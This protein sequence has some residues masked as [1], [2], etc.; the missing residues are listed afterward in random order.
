MFQVVQALTVYYKSSDAI[1]N[2]ETEARTKSVTHWNWFAAQK[3]QILILPE[4]IR[5]LL[6]GIK[7]FTTH[8]KIISK[9]TSWQ[10][11]LIYLSY[12]VQTQKKVDALG[13]C[14]V[15]CQYFITV[16]HLC[17][18]CYHQN[19]MSNY[20]GHSSTKKSRCFTVVP[21]IRAIIR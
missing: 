18:V 17:C 4:Q 20:S 7:P 3:I 21:Y 9:V 6:T 13:C 11:I 1:A 8:D 15:Q 14:T 2:K 16:H 12:V 19:C 5:V 10:S